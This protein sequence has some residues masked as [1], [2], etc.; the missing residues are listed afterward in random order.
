MIR[1][2]A[3]VSAFL[4][5]AGCSTMKTVSILEYL[6]TQN[7]SKLKPYIQCKCNDSLHIVDISKRGDE[8]PHNR[9]MNND[10]ISVTEGYRVIYAFNSLKYP[11]ARVMVERSDSMQYEKDKIKIKAEAIRLSKSA[12]NTP[13]FD[14]TIATY[15]I[16]G[17]ERDTIDK[18]SVIGN[19]IIFSNSDKAIVTIYFH[20]QGAENRVYNNISDF[21]ILREEFIRKHIDCMKNKTHETPLSI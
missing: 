16:I 14:S 17:F 9:I 18:G 8:G 2:L 21:R 11:F 20:N 13:F 3:Y 7:K 6:E 10:T 12:T 1:K 5:I 4:I 15:E 19:Y